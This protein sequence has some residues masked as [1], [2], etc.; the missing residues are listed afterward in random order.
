MSYDREGLRLREPE[1]EFKTRYTKIPIIT[2]PTL[3]SF[4]I[5]GDQQRGIEEVIIIE[6]STDDRGISV[7]IPTGSI[8]FGRVRVFRLCNSSLMSEVT[9][10]KLQQHLVP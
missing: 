8:F 10:A 3:T 4:A 9:L 5:T 6:F 1:T 2:G 7:F